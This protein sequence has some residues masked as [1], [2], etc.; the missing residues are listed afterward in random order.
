MSVGH[1]PSRHTHSAQETWFSLACGCCACWVCC[2]S[3]LAE[4]ESFIAS[5]EFVEKTLEEFFRCDTLRTGRLNATQ[6]LL[7]C[8]HLE[9]DLR[10]LIPPQAAK[11][12]QPQLSDVEIILNKF[13]SSSAGGGEAATAQRSGGLPE[14]PELDCDQFLHF[15]QT[16][17]RNVCAHVKL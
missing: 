16:L 15:S 14:S 3:D 11:H 9:Q 6:L 2:V 7:A 1:S 10:P 17:F 12:R 13:G 5:E 4:V 8:L